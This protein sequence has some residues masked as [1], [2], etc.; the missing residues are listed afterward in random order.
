MALGLVVMP[1]FPTRRREGRLRNRSSPAE[2]MSPP[3][4]GWE[5]LLLIYLDL[6]NGTP[7]TRGYETAGP[8][9]L[10][11]SENKPYH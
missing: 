4:D 7:T 6:L 3:D 8:G 1:R 11:H 5:L 9:T 2:Q 10:V